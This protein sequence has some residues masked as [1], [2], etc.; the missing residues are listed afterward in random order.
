M[1][2]PLVWDEFTCRCLCHYEVHRR[3]CTEPRCARNTPE[4]AESMTPREEVSKNLLEKDHKVSYHS[5][6]MSPELV[7][8]LCA[9]GESSRAH[10]SINVAVQWARE[11]RDEVLLQ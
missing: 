2:G 8:A 11:H 3:A 9:C 10:R 6:A 7:F 5:Y 4:E 1:E